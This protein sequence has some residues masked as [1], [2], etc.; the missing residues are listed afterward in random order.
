MSITYIGCDPGK[1]GGIAWIHGGVVRAE[2]MPETIQ[3][4]WNLFGSIVK[5]S[6]GLIVAG[7]EAVSAMPGQGVTSCFT[8]GNGF[9]H[10][11]MALTG[12]GI[13]FDR[14]RPQKWQKYLGCLTGGDKNVSKRKAQELFPQMKCTHAISDA[15]LICEYTRRT[16][17]P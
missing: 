15:L 16:T 4:V 14:I 17:T 7:L 10:L 11:E 9:G 3:D 2:K 13:T 5:E 8:F 6:T 12:W 1:S